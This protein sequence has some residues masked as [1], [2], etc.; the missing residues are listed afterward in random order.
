M[1]KEILDTLEA[2]IKQSLAGFK[3][4]LSLEN[5]SVKLESQNK[6]AR[7]THAPNES[8]MDQFGASSRKNYGITVIDLMWP[9]NT[10]SSDARVVADAIV[11]HFNTKSYIDVAVG[12]VTYKMRIINAFATTARHEVRYILPVKIRWEMVSSY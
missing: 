1:I 12:G 8:V 6:I 2:E 7:V 11:S 9:L 10:G 5:D 3:V 4:T